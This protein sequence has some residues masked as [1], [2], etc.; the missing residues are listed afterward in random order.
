VSTVAQI[1][2][3]LDPTTQPASVALAVRAYLAAE[4]LPPNF[5][6]PK[7]DPLLAQVQ[8]RTGYTNVAVLT[9]VDLP[10]VDGEALNVEREM[11]VEGDQG[12][13][14]GGLR[15]TATPQVLAG[16]QVQLKARV[17]LELGL[18]PGGFHRLQHE[19]VLR[20]PSGQAVLVVSADP[21]LHTALVL[22]LTPT[23]GK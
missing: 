8:E 22:A 17:N 23:V 14:R 19:G 16:Q 4:M 5:A 13:L 20:T 9:E 12:G 18:G 21:I 6:A 7:D 2:A 3:A 1:L 11:G 15:L 10:G